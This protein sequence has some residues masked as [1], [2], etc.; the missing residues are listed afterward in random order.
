MTLEEANEIAVIF[1]LQFAEDDI[2]EMIPIEIVEG[3]YN[4]DDERFVDINLYTYSHVI[5]GEDGRAYAF[6]ASKEDLMEEYKDK[7]LEEIKKDYFNSF[8]NNRYCL[9]TNKDGDLTMLV[10]KGENTTPNLVFVK[11]S[12][13]L[14][15]LF[16]NDSSLK[17]LFLLSNDEN[18]ENEKVNINPHYLY[19]EIKKTV[20]GQDDA[21]KNIVTTIWKNIESNHA[22]NM[23]LIGPSGVGKTEIFRCL[24][25]ILNVPLLMS[26][27]TGRSQAGYVGT[28]TEEIL[29]SLL[30]ITN[31]DVEKA[32]HAIVFID[33]FD[34]IAYKTSESGKIST[35]GVQRE[36]LKIIEDGNFTVEYKK[37][38]NS[39][40]KTIN[41][42]NITFV[43]AG[44][45]EGLLKV[46]KKKQ[47]GFDN[48]IYDKEIDKSNINGDDLIKYGLIK[49]LVGRITAGGI[50]RL[51]D[52]SLEDMKNII[53]SSLKSE[54]LFYKEFFSKKEILLKVIN[55]EEV[56]EQIAKKALASN[57]GARAIEAIVIKMFNEILF[58]ISNPE[59]NYN[60]LEITPETVNNSKK[61]ILK[62]KEKEQN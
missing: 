1:E 60:Y 56:I 55:E 54:Y 39:V 8:L 41:T 4:E 30:S 48:D 46:N 7:S 15:M 53:K 16:I 9:G 17:E 42:S 61:Y 26:T 25:K 12:A 50:I 11:D 14:L 23:L 13:E 34:K 10:F 57:V 40:E 5:K 18:E 31:G 6:R 47:I 20:I 33:E 3:Y 62:K 59:Y 35:E 32:E 36:F 38:G 24:S 27:A 43:G 51:N 21:I 2:L 45:F 29:T 22:S 52:L 49:E 44:A 58:E 19:N 37:D 28:G